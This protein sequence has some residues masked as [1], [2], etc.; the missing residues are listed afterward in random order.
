MSFLDDLFGKTPEPVPT[1]TPVPQTKP[2]AAAPTTTLTPTIKIPTATPTQVKKPAITGYDVAA[3]FIQRK[4]GFRGTPHLDTNGE[5]AI[6]FGQQFIDGKRVTK[7]MKITEEQAK[8]YFKTEYDR[9]RKQLDQYPNVWNMTPYQEARTMDVVWNSS[10]EAIKGWK[11]IHAILMSYDPEEL[12][13]LDA[14]LLTIRK[15]KINGK[16][17]VIPALEQRRKEAQEE[18]ADK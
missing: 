1:A 7:G 13:K 9:R 11:K 14:E 6:G 3:P 16:S 4:E 12:K 15:G 10:P 18:L 2:N 5:L 8:T 17:E